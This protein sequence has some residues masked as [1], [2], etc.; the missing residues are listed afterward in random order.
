MPNASVT[1]TGALGYGKGYNGYA[2]LISLIFVR[3]Y[4][5][6]FAHESKM[7]VE[8]RKAEARL[9]LRMLSRVCAA[10]AGIFFLQHQLG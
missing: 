9:P 10:D 7:E 6:H 1:S 5:L 8:Q 2:Q 3:R 4:K